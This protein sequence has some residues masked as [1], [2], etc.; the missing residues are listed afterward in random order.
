MN[1][2]VFVITFSV[3]LLLMYGKANDFC[4]LILYPFT[5]L[6]L[7]IISRKFLMDWDLLCTILYHLE[8]ETI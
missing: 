4:K 7:L 6:I 8:I 1:D 3:S 2:S 5:L